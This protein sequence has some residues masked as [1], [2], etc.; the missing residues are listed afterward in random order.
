LSSRA[1]TGGTAEVR[2]TA[3]GIEI[4]LPQNDRQ[5]ID[6]IVALKL[7]VPANQ[8]PAIDVPRPV[9]VSEKAKATASNTYQNS[10]EYGPDKAVDGNG[11]TRWAT[12]AGVQQAWLELD[13]GRPMTFKRASL[14]EAFPNRVQKFELQWLDGTEWKA[15]CSGTT[16]GESWSKSFA[17][18]TAQR[19]RLNVLES[20]NGPTIW[21]F[22]LFK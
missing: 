6:T 11:E 22:E 2:Q 8:I 1:L 3:A 5:P 14:S 17:S 19:V 13:L 16:I 4:S 7:D 12:D 9:P 20:T 21:E 10:A 15:F 18:V